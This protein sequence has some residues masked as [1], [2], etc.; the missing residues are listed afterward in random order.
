MDIQQQTTT[1]MGMMTINGAPTPTL[2]SNC[3]SGGWRVHQGH[4]TTRGTVRGTTTTTN[5]W[6]G[7]Q[8]WHQWHHNDPT[9][10][11]N[12][13]HPMNDTTTHPSLTSHCLWGG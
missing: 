5:Q 10:H 8:R 4:A 6:E 2:T 13:Q 3:S 9:P 11:T 12:P 1:M 7:C